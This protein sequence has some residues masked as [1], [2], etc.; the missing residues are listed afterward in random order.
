MDQPEKSRLVTQRSESE[1]DLRNDIRKHIEIYEKQINALLESSPQRLLHVEPNKTCS[2]STREPLILKQN[3]FVTKINRIKKYW[4][5]KV[6]DS[7]SDIEK[8]LSGDSQCSSESSLTDSENELSNDGNDNGN[9]SADMNVLR[10]LN[11]CHSEKTFTENLQQPDTEK[12]HKQDNESSSNDTSSATPCSCS[13]KRTEQNST[14]SSSYLTAMDLDTL[15]D[16]SGGE[17]SFKKS[18]S[19][20]KSF[21][22]GLD[23]LCDA[24]DFGETESVY[25]VGLTIDTASV[26]SATETESILDVEDFASETDYSESRSDDGCDEKPYSVKQLEVLFDRAV[27]QYFFKH[28][29]GFNE[30]Q[31]NEGRKGM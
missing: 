7:S 12:E 3:K 2:N 22:T 15:G 4:H 30:R 14:D 10:K 1:E 27:D 29:F 24:D 9:V 18:V 16:D 25:S 21:V 20:E 5:S 13:P 26:I 8:R 31:Q 28:P 17:V 23:S 6:K 19:D 11:N